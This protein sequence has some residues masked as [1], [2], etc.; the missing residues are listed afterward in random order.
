ML[1]QEGAGFVGEVVAGQRGELRRVRHGCVVGSGAVD[2]AR[3]TER[4]V[5]ERRCWVVVGCA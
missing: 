5:V 1:G 2:S 4:V 3:R